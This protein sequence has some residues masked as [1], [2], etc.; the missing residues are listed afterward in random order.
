MAMVTAIDGS[1]AMEINNNG[2]RNSDCRLDCNG[3]LNGNWDGKED[4]GMEGINGNGDRDGVL[5]GNS[6]GDGNRRLN[7]EGRLNGNCDGKEVDGMERIDWR[8]ME[9]LAATAM[10]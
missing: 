2:Y 9:G 10:V 4:N 6:N 1:T 7:C 8:L 5:D 3:G